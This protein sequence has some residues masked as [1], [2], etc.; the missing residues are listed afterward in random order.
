MHEKQNSDAGAPGKSKADPL[1][2]GDDAFSVVS[3]SPEPE[4]VSSE[5][6]TCCC[7]PNKPSAVT[8]I[9]AVERSLVKTMLASSH[10]VVQK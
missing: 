6:P 10:C 3:G 1:S 8:T 9:A 7:T 5:L 4:T 2:S